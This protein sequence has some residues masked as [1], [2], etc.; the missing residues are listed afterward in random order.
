MKTISPSQ[1]AVVNLKN[2]AIISA[3]IIT[4]KPKRIGDE[5]R[6]KVAVRAKIKEIR[7]KPSIYSARGWPSL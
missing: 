2:M 6:N 4:H 1:L 3:I 5:S 7:V